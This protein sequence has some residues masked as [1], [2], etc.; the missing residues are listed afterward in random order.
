MTGVARALLG[1]ITAHSVCFAMPLHRDRMA[2]MRMRM[3]TPHVRAHV[4]VQHTDAEREAALVCTV[5]V[6]GQRFATTC[7]GKPNSFLHVCEE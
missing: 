4:H 6:D 2:H 7:T 1:F 5:C 3:R